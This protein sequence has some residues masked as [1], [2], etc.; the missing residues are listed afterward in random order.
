MNE[1]N[2][3]KPVVTNMPKPPKRPNDAGVISVQG[4]LRIFDP[5]SQK[6]L[7]EKQA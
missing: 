6:T 4:H 5:Q 7:V 1:N 2:Q 3:P